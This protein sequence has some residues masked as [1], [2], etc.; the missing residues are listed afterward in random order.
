LLRYCVAI[1]NEGGGKLILGIC[2]EK[3]RRVVGTQA[4]LNLN[5]AQTRIL[6]RLRFRVTI[7]EI[8]HPD[9]RVLI[10]HLPTRPTGTAYHLDGAYFMRSGEAIVAMTEDQLRTIFDEGKPSPEPKPRPEPPAAIPDMLIHDLFFH[11]RPDLLEKV[12]EKRWEGVARDVMD[13]FSTAQL[14]VWG[15][16]IDPNINIVGALVKIPPNYWRNRTFIYYFLDASKGIGK[17]AGK[18]MA[19][20][21]SWQDS[22]ALQYADLQVNHAQVFGIWPQRFKEVGI[23]IVIPEPPRSIIASPIDHDRSVQLIGEI[24]PTL[25]ELARSWLDEGAAK[26]EAAIAR[27]PHQPYPGN[28]PDIR[29]LLRAGAWEVALVIDP[30]IS[31]RVADDIFFRTVASSVPQYSAWPIWL[32]RSGDPVNRHVQI[33]DGWEAFIVLEPVRFPWG[34]VEFQ[35]WEPAGRFYLYRLHDDD[36]VAKIRRQTPGV[37]LDLGRA[38]LRVAEAMIAGL[39][40]A[41]ALGCAEDLA[42]LGFAFRWTGLQGRVAASWASQIGERFIGRKSLDPEATA[43]VSVPLSTAPSAV[44]PFVAEATRSLFAKFGG[45]SMSTE[46][47]ERCVQLVFDRET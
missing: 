38:A 41:K 6:D 37:V 25:N 18:E 16:E 10:F 35:R 11:I 39:A 1:A 20:T 33:A 5:D 3:P 43:A 9:G 12:D 34:T 14:D 42:Q 29:E 21:Y 22:N 47:I 13:K 24:R 17:L 36:A 2:D 4:F 26:A 28:R 45:L 8:T 7:E 32:D 31:G 44:T 23:R 40:I 15:R 30:P 27:W 19:H 46:A